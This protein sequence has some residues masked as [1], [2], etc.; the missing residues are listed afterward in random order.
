MH[1]R[2]A[3]SENSFSFALKKFKNMNK[4]AVSVMS[5]QSRQKNIFLNRKMTQQESHPKIIYSGA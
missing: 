3:D 2:N 5:I 4:N 1:L